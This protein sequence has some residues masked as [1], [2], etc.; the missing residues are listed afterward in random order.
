MQ[1]ARNCERWNDQRHKELRLCANIN[2]NLHLAR[3]YINN[4]HHSAIKCARILSADIIFSE[5]LAAFREPISRKTMSYEKQII[6]KEKYLTAIDLS[7]AEGLN[8]VTRL[9]TKS[10]K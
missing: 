6:S 2:N 4:S 9:A 5:K 1:N 7:S 10:E 3:K 8:G